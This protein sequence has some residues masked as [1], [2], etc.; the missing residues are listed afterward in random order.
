MRKNYKSPYYNTTRH[1]TIIYES[2][3]LTGFA[4]IIKE[5]NEL[6]KTIATHNEGLHKYLGYDGIYKSI[7]VDTAYHLSKEIQAFSLNKEEVE[8]E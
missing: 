1:Q 5:Y 4:N 2:N 6:L 3:K 7:V 8:D